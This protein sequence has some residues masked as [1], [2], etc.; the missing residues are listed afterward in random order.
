MQWQL[1]SCQV[2]NATW[3]GELSENYNATIYVTME[4]EIMGISVRLNQTMR[5]RFPQYRHA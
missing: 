4:E 1:A 3:S 2:F 5:Q